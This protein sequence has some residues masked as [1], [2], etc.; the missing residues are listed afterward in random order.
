M[1]Q[2]D[3]RPIRLQLLTK[4]VFTLQSLNGAPT[5]A[6]ENQIVRPLQNRIERLRSRCPKA[7]QLDRNAQEILTEWLT[8]R[9]V[10][11]QVV[12]VSSITQQTSVDLDGRE[13]RRDSSARQ[14]VIGSDRVPR[15]V[16]V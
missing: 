2:P 12:R 1:H 10:E 3:L 7:E 4:L 8:E 9:R 11:G 13:R 6:G 16:E 14:D 5:R 15:G